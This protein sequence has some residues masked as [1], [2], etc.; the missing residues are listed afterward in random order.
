MHDTNDMGSSMYDNLC[1]LQGAKLWHLSALFSLSLNA[2]AHKEGK[3]E[4]VY[5]KAT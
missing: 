2:Q 3:P 5:K 4:V 1:W